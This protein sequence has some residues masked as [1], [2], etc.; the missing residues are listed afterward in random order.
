M[1]RWEMAI[2]NSNLEKIRPGK[3]IFWRKN[4]AFFLIGFMLVWCILLY[5]DVVVMR[6]K[7]KQV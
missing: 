1:V 3:D 4:E 6:E 5:V 7:P 2:R